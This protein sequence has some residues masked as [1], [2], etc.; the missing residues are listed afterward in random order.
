MNWQQFSDHLNNLYPVKLLAT[1]LVVLYALTLVEPTYAACKYPDLPREMETNSVERIH[2]DG[3]WAAFE[4]I[5]PKQ[6]WTAARPQETIIL[7]KDTEADLCRS[8]SFLAVNFKPQDG[9]N[10]QLAFSSGYKFNAN[11]PVV[12]RI[13]GS[14]I[15]YNMVV[16]GSFAWAN[17]FK[18][19]KLLRSEM[20]H[21][22]ELTIIGIA[23]TG[24]YV[25]DTFSLRG[26]GST[27]TAA[28]SFCAENY[29]NFLGFPIKKKS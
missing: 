12:L 17:N 22:K 11:R 28:Q 15:V 1:F 26:F 10:G 6:C 5:E 27:L 14:V 23:N 16:Q 29:S 21:G 2:Y 7:P 13:D 9:A 20:K 8:S 19:D 24:H 25:K 18:E 4:D 3:S